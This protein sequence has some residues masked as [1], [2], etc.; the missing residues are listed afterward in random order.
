MIPT[1]SDLSEDAR[2]QHKLVNGWYN[3]YPPEWREL[4]ALEFARSRHFTFTPV[5]IEFR[6]MIFG[7]PGNPNRTPAISAQLQWQADGTGHAVIN[8]YWDGTVKFYA[9]GKQPVGFKEAF[10]SSD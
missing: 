6:Q 5:L 1:L 2:A 10:D 4:T 8:D 9:F 7:L 3:D